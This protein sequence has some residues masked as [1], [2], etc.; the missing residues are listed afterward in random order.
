MVSTIT[1]RS[2]LVSLALALA[3]VIAVPLTATPASADDDIVAPY[4][5]TVTVMDT[6]IHCDEPYSD[7]KFNPTYKQLTFGN[8]FYQT[9]TTWL[10]TYSYGLYYFYDANGAYC[11]NWMCAP[12][13]YRINYTSW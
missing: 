1:F 7:I 13:K 11:G 3:T 5:Y 6:Y 9:G 4:T 2:A 8:D 12:D 10:Y